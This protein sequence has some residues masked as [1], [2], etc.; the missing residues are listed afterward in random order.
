[1][2][3]L[4]GAQPCIESGIC[5]A[6]NTVLLKAYPLICRTIITYPTEYVK[7]YEPQLGYH[8]QFYKFVGYINP[9]E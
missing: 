7:R 2:M 1:M 3:R 4:G 9:L 6:G 5:P 8:P